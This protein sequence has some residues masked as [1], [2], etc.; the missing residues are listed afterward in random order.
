M[1]VPAVATMPQNSGP[2][3]HARTDARTHSR[4][5]SLTHTLTDAPKHAEQPAHSDQV[6]LF[7]HSLAFLAHQFSHTAAARV[8]E[9]FVDGFAASATK[10]IGRNA[11]Q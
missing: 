6:H 4:T 11:Q 5:H 2:R 10:T 3:T 9:T 7:R 8:D 1:I